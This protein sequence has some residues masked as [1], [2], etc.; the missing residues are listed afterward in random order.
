MDP[1]HRTFLLYQQRPHLQGH[2][3]PLNRCEST[4]GEVGELVLRK[5][6]STV[7]SLKA[8]ILGDIFG[9]TMFMQST[10]AHVCRLI[11]S[12]LAFMEGIDVSA[13]KALWMQE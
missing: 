7:H 6:D 8:Q 1:C 4:E 13:T 9:P 2:N 12:S 11:N 10:H 3:R 5:N